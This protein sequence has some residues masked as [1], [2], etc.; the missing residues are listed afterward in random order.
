MVRVK[1]IY[2]QCFISSNDNLENIIKL[3]G[4]SALSKFLSSPLMLCRAHLRCSALS[5]TFSTSSSA[6][7][8]ITLRHWN[9]FSEAQNTDSVHWPFM[10]V[11][12]TLPI[13][14]PL[15]KTSTE[16]LSEGSPSISGMNPTTVTGST[17][18]AERPFCS[19]LTTARKWCR[20]GTVTLFCAAET[21]DQ[22]SELDPI[23]AFLMTAKIT[24]TPIP[25]FPIVTIWRVP[26]NTRAASK[27]RLHSAFAPTA[28]T[29]QWWSTKCMKCSGSRV[30]Q[31][32]KLTEWL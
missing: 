16:K 26:I 13:L 28:E 32:S 5:A 23:Y 17:I 31:L 8:S 4:P 6:P 29:S 15:S 20:P 2:Y 18:P 24:D 30:T 19:I 9:C 11:A 10:N 14:S 3:K 22:L 27:V 7:P 1:N 25:G 21:T 12:I